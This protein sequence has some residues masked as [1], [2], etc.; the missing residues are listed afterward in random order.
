MGNLIIFLILII[1]LLISFFFGFLTKRLSVK[2]GRKSKEGFLLGFLFSF[3]G[4]IIE[5]L[6]P[7]KNDFQLKK[8]LLVNSIV[9]FVL[10]FGVVVLLLVIQKYL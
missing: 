9:S 1:C 10:G 2:K 7:S 4:I 5:Y 3:L 6:L 8:P